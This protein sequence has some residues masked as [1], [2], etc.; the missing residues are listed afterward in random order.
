ME[1]FLGANLV[2][3]IQLISF[4]GGG[5]WLISS[6]K[7]I[8]GIQSVRLE[9]V[10]RELSE[11]R[12]VVVSIARQEERLN[13]MDHRMLSQGKRIDHLTDKLIKNGFNE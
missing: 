9:A 10:E 1:Q 12:K 5:I 2:S 11:L 7:S 13:A 4:I 3:I 8:Q 6:M